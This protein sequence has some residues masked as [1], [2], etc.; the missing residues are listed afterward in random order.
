[1][2][3]QT[4]TETTVEATQVNPEAATST[5]TKP[6]T[7]AKAKAKAGT[8][9][10]AAKPAKAKADV[11]PYLGSYP[12]LKQWPKAAGLPP[13]RDHIITARALGVGRPGTKRELA[14]AAYLRDD[15]GLYH[16]G[17]IAAALVRVV[18]GTFNPMLNV[19]NRDLYASMGLIKTPLKVKVDGGTSYRLELNSK[20]VAKVER[21]KAANGLHVAHKASAVDV[22]DYDRS[23]VDYEAHV[24]PQA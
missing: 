13:T 12:Q 4:M 5:N 10:Q 16:T 17:V 19:V 21:F 2:T 18:G 6:V 3:N 11:D 15:A 23:A 20:G 14:V 7:K 1:M 8:S 24:A 9:K 22:V